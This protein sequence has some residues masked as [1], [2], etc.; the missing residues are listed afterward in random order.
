MEE[1]LAVCRILSL[2]SEEDDSTTDDAIA[3]R[4]MGMG[5]KVEHAALTKLLGIFEQAL[6]SFPTTWEQD[7]RMLERRENEDGTLLSI[8]ATAAVEYRL[9][10][11]IKIV[12][13]V[14]ATQREL[15]RIEQIIKEM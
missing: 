9:A 15:K 4:T 8:A 13:R 7:E 3:F 12:T 10:K 1:L 2:D 5:V 14:N 11:K 6:N